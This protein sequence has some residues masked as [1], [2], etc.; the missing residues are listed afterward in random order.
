MIAYTGFLMAMQAAGMIMD[1]NE[2]KKSQNMIRL[3]GEVEKAG[4]EANLESIK[5]ESG[6]ASL[7]EM[8]Q[9]RQNLGS[10]I[11]M[12]AARG[13]S[14]SAGSAMVQ[15][16]KSIN[17]YNTDERTRRLNLLSKE[18]NL[19]AQ[20]TLSGLHTLQSETQLGQQLNKR[21]INELPVS[22]SV[23]AFRNT[24]FAK[25]WGFGLQPAQN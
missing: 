5:L 9:L 24:K 20:N 4:I 19:R 21:L 6:Q 13:T 11:A 22:S 3:G 1:I 25:Q 8:Q 12:N 14:T 17:A 10:Q 7:A 16:Q 2:T 18:A 23:D 15:S